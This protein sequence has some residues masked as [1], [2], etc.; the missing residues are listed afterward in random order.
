MGMSVFWY[1]LSA[2]CRNTGEIGCKIACVKYAP[3]LCVLLHEQVRI[4]PSGACWMRLQRLEYYRRK[5]VGF[6]VIIHC[7]DY[8]KHVGL[9][10]FTRFMIRW[11]VK[12]C[13]RHN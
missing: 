12:V 8:L 9:R 4:V 13:R 7:P 1:K 3:M 10:V 2:V 11:R 6:M 5:D